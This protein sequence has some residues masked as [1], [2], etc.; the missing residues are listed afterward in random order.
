MCNYKIPLISD[1]KCD[2]ILYY[3]G[4]VRV[5]ERESKGLSWIGK[6]GHEKIEQLEALGFGLSRLTLERCLKSCLYNFS[7]NYEMLEEER[8]ITRQHYGASAVLRYVQGSHIL[9][10]CLSSC[11]CDCCTARITTD[12]KFISE[13]FYPLLKDRIHPKDIL[14][15]SSFKQTTSS[16]KSSQQIYSVCD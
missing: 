3:F 8:R 14:Q 11:S 12:L 16:K 10:K 7:Q 6:L 2:S 9:S 1:V 13:S 4:Y 15:C 5:K